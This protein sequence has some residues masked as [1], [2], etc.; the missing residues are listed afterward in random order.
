MIRPVAEM[1]S[2]VRH[3]RFDP[4]AVLAGL[5]LLFLAA[6]GGFGLAAVTASK[7]DEVITPVATICRANTAASIELTSAG[8]CS[9]ADRARQAGPY[10]ITKAGAAGDDGAPGR[11]GKDGVAGQPG[12]AGTAGT[13]GTPGRDGAPGEDGTDG[14]AGV[15][16]AAAPSAEPG[17]S[18]EPGQP[19]ISPPCLDEPRQCRGADGRDGVDGQD[20]RDGRDGSATASETF[21]LP[22]GRVFVCPRTG[23]TDLDPMYRCQERTPAPQPTG[24]PDPTS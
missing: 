2:V 10:V 14:E 22:D 19:G 1:R 24:S 17:P 16:G 15:S 4:R 3:A 20:G 6:L 9:A 21:S 8:A 23:G 18:G 12:G 11:D 13:P 7:A 5:V